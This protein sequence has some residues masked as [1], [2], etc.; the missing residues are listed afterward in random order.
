MESL[1]CSKCASSTSA[2]SS[3][4][5]THRTAARPYAESLSEVS[6]AAMAR[7]KSAIP[8]R[9][10]IPGNGPGLRFYA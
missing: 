2:S 8:S 5:H 4:R 7:P 3:E 10:P 9:N 1:S 6:G